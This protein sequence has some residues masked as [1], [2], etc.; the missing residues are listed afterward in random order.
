MAKLRKAHLAWDIAK[1]DFVATA[2]QSSGHPN[3]ANCKVERDLQNKIA[4]GTKFD[5]ELLGY[6]TLSKQGQVLSKQDAEKVARAATAIQDIITC[7][8]LKVQGLKKMFKLCCVGIARN[9]ETRASYKPSP[10]LVG[11]PRH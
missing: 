1:R 6:E 11:D 9:S 5:D 2:Q 4:E 10:V 3:T 8:K 7:S